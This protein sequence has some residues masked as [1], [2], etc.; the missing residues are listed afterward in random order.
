[1][2]LQCQATCNLC[3][4]EKLAD[5]ADTV[6][7]KRRM[8]AEHGQVSAA[9]GAALR[10]MLPHVTLDGGN[11]VIVVT[12]SAGYLEFFSNWKHSVNKLGIT[13]FLVI[14]EDTKIYEALQ[15]GQAGDGV[16]PGI[17]LVLSPTPVPASDGHKMDYMSQGYNIL[18]SNR[19][20]YLRVLLELGVDVLYAD[21]DAV[22]IDN[23]LPDLDGTDHDLMIQADADSPNDFPFHMLCTGFMYIRATDRAK[24]VIFDW[25]YEL[26]VQTTRTINQEVFNRVVKNALLRDAIS[27]KVLQFARFPSGMLTYGFPRW[28]SQQP[29]KP[30]V[31]HNNFMVGRKAKRNR[32][33]QIGL[34]FVN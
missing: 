29:V 21:V 16:T 10:P 30:A 23:P 31:I 26:L 20:R 28:L 5:S 1:M 17:N 24:R 4:R 33:I 11:T 18:V 6:V 25:E 19:P 12:V 15:L 9:F 32:F 7:A 27:V 14:A 13:Q 2:M 3:D 34:W 22:W 8:R